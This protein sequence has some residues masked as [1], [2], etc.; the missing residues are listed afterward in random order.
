MQNKSDNSD[1][2]L[3]VFLFSSKALTL[4]EHLEDYAGTSWIKL[5]C[6]GLISAPLLL[7]WIDFNPNM[8]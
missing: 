5:I 3:I 1:A 7:T 8:K 2:S 6:C 4:V